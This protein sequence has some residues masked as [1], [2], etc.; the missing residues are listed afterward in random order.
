MV[1]KR[2]IAKQ[3][4]AGKR[5][6]LPAGPS[7]AKLSMPM[8][9]SVLPRERLLRR[10][11]AA[12]AHPVLW[13]SGPPGSGK[14]TLLASHLQSRKLPFL[15]NQLDEGDG[16]PAT[17]F[18]FLGRAAQALASA[19]LPAL[20]PESLGAIKPFARRWFREL[21]AAL[22]P[23]SVVVLDDVHSVAAES[24]FHAAL[25]EGAAQIPQGISLVLLSRQPPPPSLARFQ[26]NGTMA[27]I[28]PDELRLTLEESDD[29]ARLRG[30]AVPRSQV[31][32]LHR[33]SEGWTA[34]F[35]LLL[36]AGEVPGKGLRPLFDY[37]STE[38]L[39]RAD[40]RTQRVLIETAP[41]QALT[42]EIA[43]AL[44][45]LPDAGEVLEDLS[46]RA[47]FTTRHG[48]PRPTFQYHSL[49][50]RFL[51][52]RGEE[53]LPG[54]RRQEIRCQA[55][56]LLEADGQPEAAVDLL[57]EAGQQHEEIRRIALRHA[58]AMFGSGRIATL[59]QWLEEIPSQV[60]DGDSWTLYWLGLSVFYAEPL[61]G[62]RLLER[63]F[64][65]ARAGGDPLSVYASWAGVAGSYLYFFDTAEPLERM[66]AE[67]DQLRRR[68]VP[69]PPGMEQ[70]V[71]SAVLTLM[72]FTSPMHPEIAQWQAHCLE[73]VRSAE[74]PGQRARAGLSLTLAFFYSGEHA[75]IAEVSAL[76]QPTA[77]DATDSTVSLNCRSCKAYDLFCR[78]GSPR[79]A[80]EEFRRGLE[81]AKHDEIRFYEMLFSVNGIW[82]A[83]AAGEVDVAARLLEEE[84]RA[85]DPSSHFNLAVHEFCE[86]A[87]A[88]SRGRLVDARRWADS[89]V[90]R[91]QESGALFELNT[92]S[93][94]LAVSLIELRD[95][96][97]LSSCLSRIRAVGK[98]AGSV[99]PEH[100]CSWLEALEALRQ[101]RPEDARQ[102]LLRASSIGSA[103][104]IWIAMGLD[105]G[106]TAEVCAAALKQGIGVDYFLEVIRRQELLPEGD[107]VFLERWPRAMRI[108]TLGG[109]DLKRTGPLSLKAS[110][111]LLDLLVVIIAYGSENV[112]E[113]KV[114]DAL[115]PEEEGDL[116][117]HALETALYRLRA[118]LG[119]DAAIV[120]GNGRLGI[121]LR[122][123]WVDARAL[124][125]SLERARGDL[126][127]TREVVALYRGAFLPANRLPWV[128][129]AR[130]R[131][132]RSM[133]RYLELLCRTE[134]P[135]AE[136]MAALR[137]RCVERDPALA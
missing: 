60:R 67:W 132:R 134:G 8:M 24:P 29:L 46:R 123:C 120:H 55:A 124:E 57:K 15:W 83:T 2:P 86:A 44:T 79:A 135:A 114:I 23:G 5:P 128:E 56:R 64:E 13:V 3:R 11:D 109:L 49:L 97:A 102:P 50:R 84:R 92:M 7:L 98:R 129:S 32:R 91:T 131:L 17:F 63:A 43:A 78:L 122:R 90:A 106:R 101:G 117:K 127:Q 68:G 121:D 80:L 136:E 65:I 108:R 27:V 88:L 71:A 37:F 110:P 61:R 59:R 116:G 62:Q 66:M 137:A 20:T 35:I 16:D 105:A 115:W 31:E 118:F 75:R 85:L 77:S 103:H 4:A 133:R 74:D 107:A 54:A 130:E 72:V 36:S 76:L 112:P 93:N 58:P 34:G 94:W 95:F 113:E 21:C 42:A 73:V 28:D 52:A 70:V 87:V 104:G 1:I 126:Q 33:S 12:R 51:L 6:Q 26:V 14:T 25:P 89:A 22:P 48:G 96:E 30:C 111:R 47:C 45:G 81:I 69:L 18:H 41:V 82:A 53:V 9:Q 39:G 38:V 10:L 100:A 125:W 119:D 99:L 40:A 19:R